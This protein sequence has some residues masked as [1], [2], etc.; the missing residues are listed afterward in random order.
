M[1]V[2]LQF[3]CPR[4]T[5]SSPRICWG[6]QHRC[7]NRPHIKTLATQTFRVTVCGFLMWVLL[8]I[9]EKVTL[10]KVPA[11]LLPCRCLASALS[12]RRSKK[13]GGQLVATPTFRTKK[14]YGPKIDYLIDNWLWK[15]WGLHFFFCFYT[16]ARAVVIKEFSCLGHLGLK[17]QL[18]V[19]PKEPVPLDQS[20]ISSICSDRCCLSHCKTLRIWPL[21]LNETQMFDNT[22]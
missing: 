7:A 17:I 13:L 8:F 11:F 4:N 20:W 15:E 12:H 22:V 3:V 1:N 18:T 2:L 10:P 19:S 21:H 5:L 16:W 9:W 14:L 6:T